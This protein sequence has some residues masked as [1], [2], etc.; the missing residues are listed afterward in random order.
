ML[1]PAGNELL[2]AG[3][4]KPAVEASLTWRAMDLLAGSSLYETMRVGKP[5]C[6]PATTFRLGGGSIAG[7]GGDDGRVS[8]S[9][10]LTVTDRASIM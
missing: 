8:L 7:V 6:A 2:A 3:V 10:T 5:W 9:S 1:V 4:G